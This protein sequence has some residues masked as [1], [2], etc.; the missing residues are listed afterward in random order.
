MLSASILL[1]D[2][3]A[4]IGASV[5]PQISGTQI[6][7]VTQ[8]SISVGFRDKIH[9]GLEIATIHPNVQKSEFTASGSNRARPLV[10]G[11]VIKSL[12]GRSLD[13]ESE[14]HSL[15]NGLADRCSTSLYNP[16]TLRMESGF[17]S[18][19]NVHVPKPRSNSPR[20]G[21]KLYFVYVVD[22]NDRNIGSKLATN[23][24][25]MKDLYDRQVID[26]RKGNWILLDGDNC[27]A[28]KLVD[29]L[30]RIALTPSDTLFVYIQCHG[31]YDHSLFD[32]ATDP[33]AGHFFRFSDFDLRRRDLVHAMW[34]KQARLTVLVTDCCNTHSDIEHRPRREFA[35]APEAL[36]WKA[37]EELV[38]CYAGLVDFTS[39][40]RGQMAWCDNRGGLFTSEAVKQFNR[41][42]SSGSRSWNDFLG[43][44]K[45]KSEQAY[46]ELRSTTPNPSPELQRQTTMLPQVLTLRVNRLDPPD[47]PVRRP[48]SGN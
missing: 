18:L 43:K 40:S 14:A 4:R 3:T 31:A 45:V 5:V 17:L 8:G 13:K 21:G 20:P 33:S 16:T 47:P 27:T 32:A 19:R 1:G 12:Q 22:T 37:F 26:N 6:E 29:S 38:F 41:E 44:I 30:S 36:G 35:M 24:P 42:D 25:S 28:R 11:E 15:L 7:T 9:D 46:K 39:A 48:F 34:S 23:I 2:D 10:K